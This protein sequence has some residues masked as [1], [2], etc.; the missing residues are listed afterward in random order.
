MRQSHGARGCRAATKPQDLDD[1]PAT[2]MFTTSL[3]ARLS[4]VISD[5]NVL[6]TVKSK[7][8]VFGDQTGEALLSRFEVQEWLG[9]V[10]RTIG[11]PAKAMPRAVVS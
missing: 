10:S 5:G 11:Q 7:T 8:D 9:L 3:G 4:V 2:G 1:R 6:V